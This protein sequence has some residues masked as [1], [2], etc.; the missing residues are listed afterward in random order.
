MAT[1]LVLSI[2]FLINFLL[3]I[4]AGNDAERPWYETLPAVAMGEI[5]CF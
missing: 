1:Y 3:A 4:V 2:A 5:F